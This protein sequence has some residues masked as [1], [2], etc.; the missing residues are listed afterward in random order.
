MKKNLTKAESLQ[1]L[2]KYQKFL[3]IKIANFFFIDKKNFKLKEN[4]ILKKIKKEFKKKKIIIRS[5][6]LQEDKESQSNAG[7]FKSFGNIY[8]SLLF[9]NYVIVTEMFIPRSVIGKSLKLVEKF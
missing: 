6:A 9:F 5:S 3:N 4:I 1:F 7:K 2:S 8:Y